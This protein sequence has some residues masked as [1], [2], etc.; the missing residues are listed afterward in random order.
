MGARGD[1]R[2]V[3]LDV[4]VRPDLLRR[5]ALDHVG[6]RLACQVQQRLDVQVVRSLRGASGVVQKKREASRKLEPRKHRRPGRRR[7][8][9]LRARALQTRGV[10]L[11]A[12]QDQVEE[13]ALVDVHEL[14]VP[15]VLRV[16]RRAVRL[17]LNVPRAVLDDLREDRGLDV[18]E[19]DRGVRLGVCGSDAGERA[20]RLKQGLRGQKARRREGRSGARKR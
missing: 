5:L 2:K 15:L 4:E 18:W 16:L 19:R 20:R 3:V 10:S 1:A 13:C 7:S 14:L 17:G 8:R 9:Q 12:H 6:D 11:E